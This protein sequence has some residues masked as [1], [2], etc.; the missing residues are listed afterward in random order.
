[1]AI[2]FWSTANVNNKK[3]MISAPTV[4]SCINIK[5]AIIIENN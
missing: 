2:K 3:K 1:M 4:N 5:I